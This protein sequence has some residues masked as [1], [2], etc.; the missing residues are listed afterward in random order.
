MR[1]CTHSTLNCAILPNTSINIH[2]RNKTYFHQNSKIGSDILCRLLAVHVRDHGPLTTTRLKLSAFD[3]KAIIPHKSRPSTERLSGN[4]LRLAG[5]VGSKPF[6]KLCLTAHKFCH[7]HD[8]TIGRANGGQQSMML[9]VLNPKPK[10]R[11][12]KNFCDTRKGDP[13]VYECNYS[14]DNRIAVPEYAWVLG[15]SSK[16]LRCE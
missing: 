9:T 8:V 2:R 6:C 16:S 13:K 7:F 12:R 4:F 3:R 10:F 5:F 15:T 14:A 1:A 11:K